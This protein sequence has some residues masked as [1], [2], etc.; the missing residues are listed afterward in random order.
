[1]A[2]TLCFL[3]AT[4]FAP[5]IEEVVFRRVF[6]Q[7]IKKDNSLREVQK[8]SKY[9]SFMWRVPLI[10]L[11]SAIFSLFHL[12]QGRNF[13]SKRFIYFLAIGFILCLCCEMCDTISSSII[14]H[15]VYNSFIV[16][17]HLLDSASYLCRMTR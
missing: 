17:G 12:E 7:L 11:N 14:L 5:F 1:M 3:R 2:I 4:L 15:M 8:S 13:F 6:F 9:A 10:I 16:M